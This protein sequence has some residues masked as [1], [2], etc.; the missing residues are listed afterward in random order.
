M[1]Q[2]IPPTTI[3]VQ[4]L[5]IGFLPDSKKS[6]GRVAH[7][8]SVSHVVTRPAKKIAEPPLLMLGDVN[9]HRTCSCSMVKFL[10][11]GGRSAADSSSSVAGARAG[12]NMRYMSTSA[13]SAVKPSIAI[14]P[15]ESCATKQRRPSESSQMLMFPREFY[16]SAKV[17]SA[18]MLEQSIRQ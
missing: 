18:R 3:V 6:D 12:W 2:E 8:P 4:A 7:K 1:T 5:P 14:P 10:G 17:A 11:G 13:P 15:A 16:Y 9:N